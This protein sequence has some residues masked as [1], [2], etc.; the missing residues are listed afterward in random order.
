[1]IRLPTF[2]LLAVWIW[3]G[4]AGAVSATLLFVPAPYGRH[5]RAG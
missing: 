5:L 1:M 2:E 3:V 4:L